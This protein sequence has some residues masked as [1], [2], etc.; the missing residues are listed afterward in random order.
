[1]STF[2]VGQP[3]GVVDGDV[4]TVV[5]A[6][7]RVALLAVASHAVLDL[8]EARQLVVVDM[9]QVSGMVPLLALDRKLMFQIPESAQTQ[10]VLGP[11]HS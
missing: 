8:A 5:A 3:F 1:M 6:T 4:E 7:R 2:K 11:G 9:D 10:P